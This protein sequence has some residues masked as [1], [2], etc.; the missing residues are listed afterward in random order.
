MYIN[1][2]ISKKV[3][4]NEREKLNMKEELLTALMFIGLIA[5]IIIIG[6]IL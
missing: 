6:S 5:V 1:D 3:N 2:I 4:M